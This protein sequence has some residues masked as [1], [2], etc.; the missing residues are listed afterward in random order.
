[1]D[2][3]LQVS[4]KK[5]A[6]GIDGQSIENFDINL[7]DNLY[8]LW[9]R[10]SS[11]TYFPKAIRRVDIPKKSGGTRSLGIPTVEDRIAQMIARNEFEPVLDSSFVEDSYGFRPNKSAHQ[12]LSKARS[13]CWKFDWVIDMDIQ[14]FFI[15]PLTCG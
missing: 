5:G 6:P 15:T 8:K 11:G 10:M 4:S 7:K 9:N 13:R 14:S 12:A 3:Y 2:A 1:M